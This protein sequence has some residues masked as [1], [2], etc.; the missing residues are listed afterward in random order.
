MPGIADMFFRIA[1][2]DKPLELGL[3]KAS[4]SISKFETRTNKMGEAIS[5]VFYKIQSKLTAFTAVAVAA[6]SAY[7][8]AQAKVS[9][10]ADIGDLSERLGIST[11][12]LQEFQFAAFETG[13]S[14][15]TMNR[16]LGELTK[17]VG[18]AQNGQGALKD[19][20]DQYKISLFDARGRALSTAE[21]YMKLADAAQSASS[22]QERLRIATAAFGGTAE[23]LIPLLSRGADGMNEMSAEAQRLG[24]VIDQNLIDSASEFD[25]QWK[26]ATFQFEV[27]L[28]NL[29]VRAVQIGND[30]R[31]SLNGVVAPQQ[32]TNPQYQKFT[33]DQMRKAMDRAQKAEERRLQG[34]VYNPN[35][36]KPK[37]DKKSGSSKDRTDDVLSD[38]RYE[39]DMLSANNR[40][41]EINN[42]LR[43]AG[44]TIQTEQGR[45]IAATAGKIYDTN[46]RLKEQKD[47]ADENARSFEEMGRSAQS[48]FSDIIL[49]GGEAKGVLSSLLSSFADSIFSNASKPIFD[50]VGSAF[51]GIFG[52]GV[53]G[54]LDRAFAA[55]PTL[56]AEG[57]VMTSRGSVPLR[58][59]SEGGVAST[60]QLAMFGEGSKPEAFVPLSGGRQI[61]VE[62]RGGG[63]VVVHQALTFAASTPQEVRDQVM[64]ML[65]EIQ[66]STVAAVGVARARG[67]AI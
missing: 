49:K 31:N 12:E 54:S 53:S 65:P 36:E 34:S 57:G 16:A 14:V 41:Q 46:E 33:P 30:L 26:R 20:T 8:A 15:D 43:R 50:F 42:A 21:I 4:S 32:D 13:S 66:K 18:E 59:Y 23:E 51:S 24:V 1:A 64:R 7:A 44:T 10:V 56:F 40:E 62:M 37:T 19:V 35:G 22:P 48:A 58:R 39:L 9:E 61:P 5:D 25:K 63:G 52:G 11:K 3:Q 27:N 55:N 28:K 47:I 67:K 38:L 29:A 60:P 17:R 2:D 6:G 45:A